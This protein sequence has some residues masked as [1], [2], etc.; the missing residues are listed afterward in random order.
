MLDFVTYQKPAVADII[1]TVVY[2][3]YTQFALVNIY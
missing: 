2:N 3:T 1:K